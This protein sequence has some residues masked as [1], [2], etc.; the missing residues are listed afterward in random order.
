MIIVSSARLGIPSQA[1]ACAGSIG[2]WMKP[3]RTRGWRV[4]IRCAS[5]KNRWLQ[6]KVPAVCDTEA[7]TPAARMAATMRL[8][9][10]LLK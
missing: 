4:A 3:P 9:G 5:V 6:T 2:R 10:R 1:A 8:I 7:G